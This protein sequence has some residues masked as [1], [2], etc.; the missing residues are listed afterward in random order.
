MPTVRLR[1][2]NFS[3]QYLDM[4]TG[5]FYDCYH[6]DSRIFIA[7]SFQL[8]RAREQQDDKY[9]IKWMAIVSIFWPALAA[10]ILF[11]LIIWALSWSSNKL[12]NALLIFGNK[13]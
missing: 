11:V 13:V 1:L 8:I 5:K 7:I 2:D 10:F 6:M 3:L 12:Q 4:L 9:K